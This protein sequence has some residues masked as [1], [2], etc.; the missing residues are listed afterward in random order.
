MDIPEPL[1]D[2][3]IRF[4]LATSADRARIIGELTASN[5]GMADLWV[6]LVADEDLRTRFEMELLGRQT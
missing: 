3:L 5:P 1:R 4:L 6:D 2:D